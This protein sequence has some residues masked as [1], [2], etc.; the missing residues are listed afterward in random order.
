MTWATW[1]AACAIAAILAG[2]SAAF[3]PLTTEEATG[4]KE[5]QR[6]ADEVTRHYGVP[7]VRVYAGTPGYGRAAGTYSYRSDWI[8]LRP[9]S[10]TG[11]AFY[12]V[13]S[14]ELGHATLSHRPVELDLAPSQTLA[15]LLAGREIK[16]SPKARAAIT[17]MENA[18]NHRGV[19]ILVRFARHTEREA[20]DRYRAYFIQAHD[21][22]EGK[23]IMMPVGHAMP[24]EQLRVLW[25]SFGHTPPACETVRDEKPVITECPYDDWMST[26]CKAGQPLPPPTTWDTGI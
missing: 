25:T 8:F 11:N 15:D 19:E 2:C 21:S 6:I 1:M 9:S 13:L 14:H 4:L 7:R 17:A 22:R 18:A 24:C 10:L 5:A 26:G 3:V 23:N 12:V 20:L 16:I